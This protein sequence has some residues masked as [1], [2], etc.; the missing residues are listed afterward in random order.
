MAALF[1]KDSNDP[2]GV[3]WVTGEDI[4]EEDRIEDESFV[5]IMQTDLEGNE[6]DMN[7]W[8]YHWNRKEAEQL[9]RF[10]GKALGKH[11]EDLA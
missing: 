2:D 3:L 1:L 7:P 8:G 10:L 11:V 4:P 9:F 5:A 6:T